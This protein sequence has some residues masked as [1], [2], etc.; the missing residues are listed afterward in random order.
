MSKQ[1]NASILVIIMIGVG[2]QLTF[3][4]SVILNIIITLIGL[5]YLIYCRVLF[6]MLAIMLLVAFP[7]SLGTWWSFVAFGVADVWHNAWI[8]STRLYA[9]LCLGAAVTLTVNVK[10][11]LLSLS[12]HLHLSATFAYGLLAA[13]NLSPRVRRQVKTIRY[14]AQLRG[15]TYHLWQPQLYFKSVL[16]ALQWSGD[17]A[18]AMTSHGFSEGF[19]RSTTYHDDL[20][21]WQWGLAILCILTFGIVAFIIKPW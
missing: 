9:Y 21:K 10:Q 7:L 19:P 4:K 16:A 2:L 11:L 15:V 17:L 5:G 3:A 20:P 13:F 18:E 12:Q 14:A 1:L 8:Y 6:K